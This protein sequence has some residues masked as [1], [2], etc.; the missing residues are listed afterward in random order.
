MA[1]E[2]KKPLRRGVFRIE[3]GGDAV[4][5]RERMAE[6]RIQEDG[7]SSPYHRLGHV[8]IQEGASLPSGGNEIQYQEIRE[9][10]GDKE[11]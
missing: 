1:E 9:G 6:I 11:D 7:D 4:R 2:E 5:V 10:L 3:S 8:P